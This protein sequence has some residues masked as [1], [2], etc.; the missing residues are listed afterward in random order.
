MV[1]AVNFIT[2]EV[3]KYYPKFRFSGKLIA[4]GEEIDDR[5][6]L[7]IDKLG[8]AKEKKMKI[9]GDRVTCPHCEEQFILE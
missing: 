4:Q 9:T 3:R 8:T 5:W 1:E 2:K 7:I 6:E